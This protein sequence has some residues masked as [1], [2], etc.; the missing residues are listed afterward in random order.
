MEWW[1]HATTS[2]MSALVASTLLS[3]CIGYAAGLS[4]ISEEASSHHVSDMAIAAKKSELSVSKVQ[5][6]PSIAERR[7]RAEYRILREERL[8]QQISDK[9]AKDKIELNILRD[10]EQQCAT[11]NQLLP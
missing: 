8:I 7:A 1:L 4:I 5:D 3:A 9:L 11:P 2:T 6:E 10:Q